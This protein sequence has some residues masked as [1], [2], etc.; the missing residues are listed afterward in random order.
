MFEACAVDKIKNLDLQHQHHKKINNFKT[1]SDA[2][3]T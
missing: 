1:V 2:L 3:V